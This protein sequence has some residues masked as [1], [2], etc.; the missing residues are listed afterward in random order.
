MKKFLIKLK[1]KF[2]FETLYLLVLGGL[3]SLS[4]PPFNFFFI[5]FLTFSAF[6][7]FFFKKLKQKKIIFF[8]YYGWL[9]G[10]GYFLTN[11]YWISIS[12]TFDENFTFLIPVASI[13]IPSFLALFYSLITFLYRLYNPKNV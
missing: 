2:F 10:F 12:L 4:L 11:L 8:F 9:F 13:I 3:S 5:N 1:K 7:I 6:F